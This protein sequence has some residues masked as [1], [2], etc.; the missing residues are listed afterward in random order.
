MG[1]VIGVCDDF[2]GVG[3]CVWVEVNEFVRERGRERCW[4][5]VWY[6]AVGVYVRE[7]REQIL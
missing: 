3:V 2:E 4:V 5:R 6:S 1:C 7:N